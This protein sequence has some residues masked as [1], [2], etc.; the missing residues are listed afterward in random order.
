MSGNTSREKLMLLSVV[1]QYK[2]GGMPSGNPIAAGG[3]M[4]HQRQWHYWLYLLLYRLV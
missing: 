3:T 2:P 1:H 4:C